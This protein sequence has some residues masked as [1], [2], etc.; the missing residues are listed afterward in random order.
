MVEVFLTSY[1]GHCRVLGGGLG[2]LCVL[3]HLGGI[4]VSEGVWWH[5]GVESWES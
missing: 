1:P 2:D 5:W 3:G 4:R